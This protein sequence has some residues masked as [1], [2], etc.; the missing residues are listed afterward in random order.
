RRGLH[1]ADPRA[2]ARG[3]TTLEPAAFLSGAPAA[4]DDDRAAVRDLGG[5]GTPVLLAGPDG[6]LKAAV[7]AG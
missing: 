2:G 5:A 1:P 6:E 3:A 7:T 4:S